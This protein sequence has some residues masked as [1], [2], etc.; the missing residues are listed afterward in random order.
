MRW[1]AA[2]PKAAA[3]QAP[4]PA[5]CRNGS[6]QAISRHGRD[7]RGA[8]SRVGSSEGRSD[9]L[10]ISAALHR[11]LA[12]D[13]ERELRGILSR[14]GAIN[15]DD[16]QAL[17]AD[18]AGWRRRVHIER[19]PAPLIEEVERYLPTILPLIRHVNDLR[20]VI[21]ALQAKPDWI[22]SGNREHWNDALAH[23]TGLRIVT[24]QAMDDWLNVDN[25]SGS[26]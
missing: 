11:L 7:Y 8:V 20:P 22:I 2:T 23:R 16:R 10:H 13:V 9:A 3:R 1:S 14:R 12:V 25:G 19:V 5:E 17:E 6:A 24:P 4:G 21:S 15:T 26:S 18:F